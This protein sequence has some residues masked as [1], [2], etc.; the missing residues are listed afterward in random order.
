MDGLQLSINEGG[1]EGKGKVLASCRYLEESFSGVQQ[2]RRRSGYGDECRK[3]WSRLE[4]DYQAGQTKRSV[5][6]LKPTWESLHDLRSKEILIEVEHAKAHRTEKE[7]QQMSL[8]EKLLTEGNEK[9]DELAKEGAMLNGG[10]TAQARA[11]TIQQEREEV[12]AVLQYVAGF[13]CLVEEWNMAK[14]RM[15]EDRGVLPKEDGNQLRE[16]KGIRE[17]NFLTSAVGCWRMWK[18]K[19][20]NGKVE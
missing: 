10:F 18:E 15:L 6:R 3:A 19:K 16:N 17:E 8:F 13:H 4:N 11:S 14:K 9:A 1:K 12:C 2:E 5:S 7:R 20:R